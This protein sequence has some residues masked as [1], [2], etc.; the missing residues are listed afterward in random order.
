M[1]FTSLVIDQVKRVIAGPK[2]EFYGIECR[3]TYVHGLSL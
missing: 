3:Y 1:D 2:K